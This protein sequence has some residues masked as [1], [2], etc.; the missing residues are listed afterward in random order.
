MLSNIAEVLPLRSTSHVIRAVGPAQ[1]GSVRRL[2]GAVHALHHDIMAVPCLLRMRSK[3]T[4]ATMEHTVA[5][6]TARSTPATVR[7]TAMREFMSA[8]T[9]LSTV[10]DDATTYGHHDRR[11]HDTMGSTH[12]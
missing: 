11:E 12:A 5:S 2:C 3:D 4:R 1:A 7:T 6:T 9:A 8:S 10:V